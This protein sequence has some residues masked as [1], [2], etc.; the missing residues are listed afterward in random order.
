MSV[1]SK[2]TMNGIITPVNGQ[3]TAGDT[4]YGTVI[5]SVPCF[6]FGNKQ[7]FRNAQMQEYTPS[8]QLLFNPDV[9]IDIN[10]QINSVINHKGDLVL[11]SGVVVRVEKNYHPKKGLVLIQAF[12]EKL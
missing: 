10:Y 5:N 12:I 4:T 9:D 7:R 3:D 8:F 11:Q 2:L 1:K 6:V